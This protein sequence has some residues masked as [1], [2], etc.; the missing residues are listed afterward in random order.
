MIVRQSCRWCDE[1]ESSCL[2]AYKERKNR[3]SYVFY[4]VASR[5]YNGPTFQIAYVWLSYLP[6]SH[7]IRSS[8][9]RGPRL[10]QAFVPSRRP[11][12]ICEYATTVFLPALCRISS[13]R[14]SKASFYL[15]LRLRSRL[16]RTT[17]ALYRV[18]FSRNTG[19]NVIFKKKVTERS[20]VRKSNADRGYCSNIFH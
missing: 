12:S 20:R 6:T 9:S 4:D 17:N 15:C 11:F 18:R 13:E 7:L 5:F 14:L 19:Q 1:L 10:C 2:L 16:S 8:A 3:R